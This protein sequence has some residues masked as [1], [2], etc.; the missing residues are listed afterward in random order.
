MLLESGGCNCLVHLVADNAQWLLEVVSLLK[1]QLKVRTNHARCIRHCTAVSGLNAV[2]SSN[3]GPHVSAGGA[4]SEGRPFA[5]RNCDHDDA[6]PSH[7]RGVCQGAYG[8]TLAVT[9]HERHL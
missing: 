3:C 7:P 4:S 6:L 2:D 1:A 5:Q 9:A 8:H